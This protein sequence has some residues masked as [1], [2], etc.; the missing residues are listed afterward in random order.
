MSARKL[1]I[2]AEFRYVSDFETGTSIA[3]Q[4]T[5]FL[6]I[7]ACLPIHYYLTNLLF[8]AVF[9][10]LLKVSHNATRWKVAGSISDGVFDF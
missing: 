3:F 1:E 7:S 6:L 9:S 8:N 5:K 2:R 4:M 10:E